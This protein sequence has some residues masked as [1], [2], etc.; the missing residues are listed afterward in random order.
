MEKAAIDIFLPVLESA[1]IY[2]SHYCK[3]CGRDTVT[4]TDMDYGWK[5]AAR[6]TLGNKLGSFFPEIYEEEEDSEDEEE[7]DSEE[8]EEE[9]FTRYTGTEELY[10]KMNEV[11]DTWNDWIPETPAECAIKNAIDSIDGRILSASDGI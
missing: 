7:E 4:S 5:Y 2:A 3:A 10:V 11:H 9:E 6:I 1:M 8:D